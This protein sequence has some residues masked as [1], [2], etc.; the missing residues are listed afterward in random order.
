MAKYTFLII[1]TYI[2]IKIFQT[3]LDEEYVNDRK[4]IVAL[5]LFLLIGVGLL[6]YYIFYLEDEE[7][8]KLTINREKI[9]QKGAVILEKE[10]D[11]FSKKIIMQV[12]DEIISDFVNDKIFYT[13][14]KRDSIFIKNGNY[15]IKKK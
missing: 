8:K 7:Q 6:H 1:A 15:E 5:Y 4:K 12:E 3:I 9:A 14:Q 2:I 11:F 13:C 10:K